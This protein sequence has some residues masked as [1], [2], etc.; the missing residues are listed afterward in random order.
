MKREQW[1]G[2]MAFVLAAAGSAVGLGNVWKFPYIAGKYGGAAFILIYLACIAVVGMPI[3][4]AELAIGRTAQK[5]PVSAFRELGGGMW[6]LVGGMGVLA[7][8]IIL[9]Y[10]SVVAGWTIEFAVRSFQGDYHQ[11]REAGEIQ[12]SRDGWIAKQISEGKLEAGTKTLDATQEHKFENNMQADAI[13]KAFG[14]YIGDYHRPLFWHVVFMG[15]TIFIVYFGVGSGIETASKILM[16]VLILVIAGVAVRGLTL[17][18]AWEGVE[19]LIYPNF[20]SIEPK[21]IVEALGHAFFTLSLGMGAMIT[22]GSYLKQESNIFKCALLVVAADTGIA[23]LAGFAIFPAVFAYGLEPTKG[24]GLIFITL[25]VVF[26]QMPGGYLIGGLFFL[27][28]TVAALTSAISLLE[29]CVAYFIDDWDWSRSKATLVTGV[30]I[31]LLGIP[32]ALSFAKGMGDTPLGLANYTLAYR[33]SEMNFFDVV[34]F[35][36][37]N[38]LLPLG[39]LLTALF[40][41]WGWNRERSL[42]AIAQG[43]E[44]LTATWGS[45]WIFLCKWISP[46]LVVIVLLVSAKIIQF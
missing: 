6:W 7:G 22:Y 19:F 35:L 12:T 11:V 14:E 44:G 9:S 39:G 15:L 41:G 17:P 5:S 46:V 26:N 32:S 23:L 13:G 28:L 42:E 33:G 21:A 24:P 20:S 29:V 2:R 34:D 27:A 3:M 45:G 37:A 16:P 31:I 25:P 36:A 18:G 43:D 38:V 1:G 10:Y 40:I 8:Y 4:L 30:V